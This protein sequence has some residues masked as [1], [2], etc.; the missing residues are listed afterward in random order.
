MPTAAINLTGNELANTIYG[1]AGANVLDGKRRGRRAGRPRR[2]RHLRFTTALGGGNIDAIGWLQRRR[3]RD[4]ARQ[5]GVPRAS[6]AGALAARRVQHRVG[7]KPGRRPRH[8]Q[9]RYRRTPVRCR[10]RR[11]RSAVQFATLA[12]G[13]AL[14]ASDFVVIWKQPGPD[15][16]FAGG[17]A[18]LDQGH[19]ALSRRRRPGIE[20]RLLRQPPEIPDVRQH[21]LGEVGHRAAGGQKSSRRLAPQPPALRFFDA[22]VGDGQ[23]SRGAAQP[24][25]GS[26]SGCRSTSPPRRSAS[27]TSA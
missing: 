4:P 9:Q 17:E 7:G 14:T 5:R 3:R 13:L 12:A 16:G 10:R 26:S 6:H 22:G 20:L 18:A 24:A 27:R 19:P 21:L 2:C 23:F 25:T 15:G 8:L 11:R 1:N